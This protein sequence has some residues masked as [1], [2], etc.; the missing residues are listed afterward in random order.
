ME[1]DIFKSYEDFKNRPDKSVNGVSEDFSRAYTDYRQINQTNSGCWD[2]EDFT[3]C[4]DCTGCTTLHSS[5]GFRGRHAT[6]SACLTIAG[7]SGTIRT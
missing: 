3:G 4:E 2:C 1:T 7:N 5:K 6:D